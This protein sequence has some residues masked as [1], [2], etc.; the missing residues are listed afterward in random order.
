LIC[1]NLGPG[2][3]FYSADYHNITHNVFYNNSVGI[4]IHGHCYNATIAFNTITNEI[5]CINLAV[6]TGAQIVNNTLFGGGISID[7]DSYF[8]EPED[9]HVEMTSNT[10]GGRL[11]GYWCEIDSQSIDISSYGQ[12]FIY[13]S[14]NLTFYNGF[15]EGCVSAIQT[16]ASNGTRIENSTISGCNRYGIDSSMSHAIWVRNCTMTNCTLGGQSIR[17]ST[18]TS[19]FNCTFEG[20]QYGANIYEGMNINFQNCSFADEFVGLS[21]GWCQECSILDNDFTGCS[22]DLAGDWGDHTIEGNVVNG[23]PLGYFSDLSYSTIDTSEFGAIIITNCNFTRFEGGNYE[24]AGSGVQMYRCT[25]CTVQGVTSRFNS[26]AGVK[27]ASCYNCTIEDCILIDNV[28]FGVEIGNTWSGTRGNRIVQCTIKGN[29]EGIR[30]TYDRC[31]SIIDTDIS[32]NDELGVEF[33]HASNVT[34]LRCNITNNGY[35][36][37]AMGL[38]LGYNNICDNNISSNV[39]FGILDSSGRSFISNNTIS[40]NNGDGVFF[41]GGT[42]IAENQIHRNNGSGVTSSWG[43]YVNISWNWICNNSEYGIK[44][45]YDYDQTYN[46]D[47]FLIGNS[48]GDNILGNAL[49]NGLN[50]LWDDGFIGNAWLDWSGEGVYLVPGLAGSIDNHP[51]LFGGDPPER[52]PITTTTTT[53]GE[54]SGTTTPDSIPLEIIAIGVAIPLVVVVLVVVMI[55]RRQ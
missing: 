14:T 38:G 15:F 30:L 34:I 28:N 43:A 4:D 54:T 17:Y 16:I 55:K 50:N 1:N 41:S 6:C 2:I 11:I 36:G 29:E 24:D 32:H 39:R 10:L 42:T 51:W 45:N 13:R 53:S 27:L 18:N 9:Y 40:D 37:L 12:V 47:Y 20:G 22:I 25:N 7:V 33:Y 23:N 5:V 8:P 48:L 35:I 26:E 21:L 52:P 31:T 3:R 19:I 46:H 44:I 49:D